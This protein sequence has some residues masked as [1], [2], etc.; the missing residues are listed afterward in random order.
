MELNFKF[1]YKLEPS[2]N[3]FFRR[4]KWF[5]VQNNFTCNLFLLNSK[6]TPSVCFFPP[7]CSFY[8][9]CRRSPYEL[10]TYFFIYRV[11][12]ITNLARVP[13]LILS[14]PCLRSRNPHYVRPSCCQRMLLLLQLRAIA[15][16]ASECRKFFLLWHFPYTRQL[17]WFQGNAQIS[18]VK[19]EPGSFLPH[20]KL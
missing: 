20:W 4:I 8:D 6:L 12:S 13:R 17:L 16:T 2:K 1:I 5:L 11:L 15:L 3:K 14:S 18:S 19:H 9:A 7:L 10:Y